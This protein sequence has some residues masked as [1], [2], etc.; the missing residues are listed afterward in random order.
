MAMTHE[1]AL[2]LIRANHRAVL[3]TIKRDG[4]PQLSHVSYLLDDDGLIKI[5][6]TQDRAKTRNLQR[7]SRASLSIITD[8]WSQYLVVEGTCAVRTQDVAAELRHV[9]ERIT[10][11][12]HP[13][14]D[15]FDC[16]MVRDRRAVLEITVDRCYPLDRQA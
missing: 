1:Q 13:D 10:G 7:D 6:V 9:Y 8:H 5:S 11:K 3:A 15:E 2:D 14:W 4:R 12:P 16:A